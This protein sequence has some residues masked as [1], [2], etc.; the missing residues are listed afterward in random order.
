[1]EKTWQA[2]TLATEHA[3]GTKIKLSPEEYIYNFWIV[4]DKN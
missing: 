2:K 4:Y 3:K 1:M